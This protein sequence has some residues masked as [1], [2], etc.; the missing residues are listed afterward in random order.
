MIPIIELKKNLEAVF[1]AFDL[2]IIIVK[3]QPFA[4]FGKAK[5]RGFQNLT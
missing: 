2:N 1:L 4:A 5:S 3:I